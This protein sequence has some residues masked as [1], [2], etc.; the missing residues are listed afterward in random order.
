[1]ISHDYGA[2]CY[3]ESW[4]QLMPLL[5][6]INHLFVASKFLVVAGYASLEN[7]QT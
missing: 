3:V 5:H 7:G 2:T 6:I 1:M 4:L